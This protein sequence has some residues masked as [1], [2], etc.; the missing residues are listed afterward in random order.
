M[1]TYWGQGTLKDLPCVILLVCHLLGIQGCFEPPGRETDTVAWWF[2]CEK[3]HLDHED[4]V[5]VEEGYVGGGW[6]VF[7]GN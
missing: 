4:N 2:L 1:K 7:F 5:T 3:T 6:E